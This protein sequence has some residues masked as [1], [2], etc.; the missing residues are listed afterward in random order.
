MPSVPSR[1]SACCLQLTHHLVHTSVMRKR[2]PCIFHHSILFFSTSPS[3]TDSQ[4]VSVQFQTSQISSFYP[5]LLIFCFFYFF[6]SLLFISKLR[7]GFDFSQW[8]TMVCELSSSNQEVCITCFE[9]RY[10][11]RGHIRPRGLEPIKKNNINPDQL[12]Q[13][14]FTIYP[15]TFSLFPNFKCGIQHTFTASRMS[16]F[17]ELMAN[18]TNNKIFT[19]SFNIICMFS[20]SICLC[21]ADG[22]VQGWA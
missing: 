11:P 5:S 22:Q 7:F 4:P 13:I 3:L 6:L 2:T 10:Q 21:P 12:L 20:Y 8:F 18:S 14:S 17:V 19:V 15:K 9:S 1:P 16:C